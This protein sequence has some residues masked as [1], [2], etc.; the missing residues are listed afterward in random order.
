[1][2]LFSI[3]RSR[4]YENPSLDIIVI[5]LC[6]TGG[7]P[8]EEAREHCFQIQSVISVVILI[9]FQCYCGECSGYIV[10]ILPLL[11]FY[12]CSAYILYLVYYNMSLTRSRYREMD[13][14]LVSLE[15]NCSR[16]PK[17]PPIVEEKRVAGEEDPIKLFLGESLVQQRNKMLDN[18]VQI[19]Q[20]LSTIIGVHLRQAVTLET[21][22]HSRY[23][24]IL[25]FPYL[26]VRLMQMLWKNG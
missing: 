4:G 22:L 6:S 23:K 24:L 7:C 26:K 14:E 2:L 5:E 17:K 3:N 10:V 18:F 21:L 20:R 19:L 1:M 25:I 15:D 13:L 11:A 8:L 12:F 16:H 9:S